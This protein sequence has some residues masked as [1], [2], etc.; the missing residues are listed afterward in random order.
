M[1]TQSRHSASDR[2]AAPIHPL[3]V[4]AVA[5]FQHDTTLEGE[6]LLTN[7]LGSID[8]FRHSTPSCRLF[9]D[10]SPPDMGLYLIYTILSCT[11]RQYIMDSP[12][13]M[14]GVAFS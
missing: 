1:R 13:S 4:W 10:K 2:L 12:N 5:E 7:I 8:L 14:D 3:I 6:G 9:Q 11:K